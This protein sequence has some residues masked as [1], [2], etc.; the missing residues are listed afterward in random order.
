MPDISK[1]KAIGWA[2][3][4]GLEETLMKTMEYWVGNKTRLVEVLGD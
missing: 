4:F 3:K 2:P 1:L